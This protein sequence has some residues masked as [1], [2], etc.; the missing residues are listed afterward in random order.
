MNDYGFIITRH[1]NSELT[2]KY[3]N[4]CIQ[5]IRHFYPHRKI[6]IID[7]NSAKELVISFNNYENIEVI[8]SEFPG[9]GELLPYYYY[10]KR[11]FF[12]NAIIIHDSVFFHKR[13][14]FEKLIDVNVL[15]FWHFYSD[16]ECVSNSVEIA[17]VLNNSIE[18]KNKLT[19]H[20]KILG[21]DKFNWFGCFGSQAFINHD[22]LL[23]LERKYNIS[24]LTKV[25]ICRKDRCCLERVMGVIFYSEY[26]A[27]TNQKSLLGNIF[28]YQN[29]SNYTYKNYED[30]V[31]NNKLQ[32]PIVKV[33]T[34]R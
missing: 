22:F 5:C 16:N 33:W 28:K 25:I 1:V 26:P 15:P 2:N 13:V 8:E 14:N 6:V 12:N 27:I 24:K 17:G 19:M 18:I 7:D 10:I 21:L 4:N 31:K 20:N 23:Y 32:R 30:D 9:R 3:W 11:K 29:F 34:G